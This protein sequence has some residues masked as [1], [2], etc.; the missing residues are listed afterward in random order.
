MDKQLTIMPTE[1]ALQRPASV[2]N[3]DTFARFIG[4]IDA[5]PKTIETYTRAIRQ[6]MKWLQANDITQPTRA[7]ILAYRDELLA[8]V[9]PSTVQNYIVAVRQL[10][11]WLYQEGSYPNVADKIKGAK[12]DRKNK[13]DYLRSREVKDVL[14][15]IDT[16]EITGKRD[17]ALFALMVTC[18]LRTIEVARA[19]IEDMR[20][21]GD[22]K[23]LYIQGKGHDEKTE[24]VKLA[25]PIERA[26][27]AYLAAR[28]PLDT[29]A[30][31]FASHSNN[32]AGERITTRSVSGIVK[33][34]L[35]EAGYDS[36]YLTAHSL[37]HTAGTLN[38]LNGGTVEETQQLLRHVDINTTMIYL[39]H[40]D[41]AKNESEHRIAAAIF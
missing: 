31:L 34:R 4:Y 35:V 16:D 3:A 28:G 32:N 2:I 40:I 30:P 13:K 5:K 8:T 29:K 12:L 41:R 38:L 22:S 33:R 9:K 1:T 6:F 10:F 26:L 27:R 24:Y 21:V 17:Y 39:H 14:S 23:V 15:K 19:N 36:E 25:E 11:A 20:T 18:G 37:R 7:D